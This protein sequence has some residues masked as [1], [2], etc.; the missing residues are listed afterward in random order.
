MPKGEGVLVAGA[1]DRHMQ[2]VGQDLGNMQGAVAFSR[3]HVDVDLVQR[4]MQAIEDHG[5]EDGTVDP[6]YTGSG[7]VDGSPDLRF[8]KI[9]DDVA[10][11]VDRLDDRQRWNTNNTDTQGHQVSSRSSRNRPRQPT[12]R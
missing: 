10:R 7:Q 8:V 12:R 4:Q 1:D 9:D 2:H 5:A 3:T 11:A 6:G